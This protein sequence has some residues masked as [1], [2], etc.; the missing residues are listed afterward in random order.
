MAGNLLTGRIP[1]EILG[2]RLTALMADNNMMTG[3]IPSTIASMPLIELSLA[4]N[5]FV[6]EIPSELIALQDSLV[7]CAL[8]NNNFTG[9][10]APEICT[11]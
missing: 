4:N 11:V 6:G 9:G 3:T 1:E 8:E 10:A 5:S 7:L 2:L